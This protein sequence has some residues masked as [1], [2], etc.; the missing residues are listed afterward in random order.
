MNRVELCAAISEKSGLTK[1]DA[2]KMV[3]AFT[4][5]VT[6]TLKSGNEVTIAGFGSFLAKERKG[7]VGVNPRTGVKMNINPVR[8]AKFKVGINL[9]KALKN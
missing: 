2:E 4:A 9:K 7:R 5:I 1:A 3:E 8:V 6:D